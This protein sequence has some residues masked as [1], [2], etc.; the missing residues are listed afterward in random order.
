MLS[1]GS[2]YL[3]TYYFFLNGIKIDNIKI[4]YITVVAR[5]TDA[6]QCWMTQVVSAKALT[7]M[8]AVLQYQIEKSGKMLTE[9]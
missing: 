1:H 3:L 2:I 4:Y 5:L 8:L 7:G 6:P 9:E